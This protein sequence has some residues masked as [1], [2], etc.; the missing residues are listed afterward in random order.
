MQC[1]R[2]ITRAAIFLELFPFVD[3]SSLGDNL[4]TDVDI[5]SKLHI[6]I[7]INVEKFSALEQATHS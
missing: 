6:Q 2:T 4:N 1:I 5:H 3:F 7:D